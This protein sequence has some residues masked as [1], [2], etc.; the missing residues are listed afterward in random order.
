MLDVIVRGGQVIDGTGSARRRADIGIR[1]GRIVSV[2]AVDVDAGEVIDATGRVVT[3]GFIDVH[4]HFDAQVFW[5]GA[6]TPSPFH[7][8]TTALAGNC[9]FSIAPLSSAPADV[10]YLLEMLAR[11]EGM[12]VEA[13]RRGVPWDWTT[14][15]DYLEAVRGRLGINA[16]FMIGHS[17]IRRLI[18]GAE[19]TARTATTDEVA[20]MC[21]ALHDG[22][23]AGGLG[24]SS[25][26]SRTHNDAH[27]DMVPSRA[28]TREELLA[29]CE[30]TGA[31]PGTALEFIPMIGPFEP[32]AVELMVD[33][34]TTA[35]RPL[36][37][38][39]LVAAPLS[40]EEVEAKLRPGDLAR[41]RG[42]RVAALTMPLN[43][44]TRLSFASGFVL[45][46]I[47]GWEAAMAAPPAERL[48]LMRDDAASAALDTSAQEKDHPLS[49]LTRWDAH[50]IFDVVAPENEQYRGRGVGDIA[51]DE[52]RSPWEVLRSIVI[53]DELKT[54][55]GVPA[56][57]VSTAD[58]KRRIDVVRDRRTVLGASD[59]GAHLDLLATFNYPTVILGDAVRR[60]GVLSL[61]EAVHHLTDAPARLYGLKD[62]GRITEGAWADLVVLDPDTVDSHEIAMRFDLPGDQGRLYAESDGIDHVLVAGTAVVRHG[63]LTGT[64]TGSLLRSGVDTETASLD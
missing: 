5:D 37:W 33:M 25:S 30:A 18:M 12:P 58:W 57:A 11:V 39:V 43:I 8:V 47:P 41:Q 35:G 51:K 32:W 56:P 40:D 1:D 27:G 62:R 46:A 3:P 6:L 64:T 28:A 42:G 48:A 7:G 59:A 19:A 26:W 13:L 15:A 36:N 22:L 63:A 10:E 31:H 9:G 45:D 60:H 14:S 2:G 61:E 4:T 53:A 49:R 38:N 50:V 21:A 55:F 24:F 20:A 44:A 17:A 16:G 29:L 34:S 54:S 23:E 52:G